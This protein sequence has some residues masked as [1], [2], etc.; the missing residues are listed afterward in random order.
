MR[1]GIVGSGNIGTTVARLA[2]DAGHEVALS[3]S[4]GPQTLTEQV[5]ELGPNARALSMEDA[6]AWG[7]VVLLAAPFKVY[8]SLPAEQLAGK[9]VVDAMNY[10]QQRDGMIADAGTNSS[11]LVARALPGARI[12]KAFNTMY[13]KTLA[14]EGKPHAPADERNVLFIAGDDADAKQAVAGLI[15]QLG[16]TAVDTGTL[17]EGAPRQQPDTPIYNKPMLPAQAREILG[18]I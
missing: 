10:Y 8:N 9:I 12:V 13:F 6:A 5:A 1:I 11:E 17:A 18:I 2:I 15:E 3:N 4:R 7:E 14:S 16:F